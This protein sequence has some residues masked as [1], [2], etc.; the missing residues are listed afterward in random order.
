MTSDMESHRMPCNTCQSPGPDEPTPPRQAWQPGLWTCLTGS[1][2]WRP[3]QATLPC[4]TVAGGLLQ[5]QFFLT[6]IMQSTARRNEWP[7]DQMAL[8]CDVTKKNRE[9]FRTPWEGAYVHGLF[10]EGVA[11]T[12]R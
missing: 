9:E 12:S 5:P 1:R 4:P 6:A 7:L 10:M 3:G 8:Q 11:G 2:S